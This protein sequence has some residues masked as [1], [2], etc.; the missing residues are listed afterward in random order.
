VEVICGIACLARML[1]ILDW[2]AGMRVQVFSLLLQLLLS[3]LLPYQTQ[4]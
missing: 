4:Q 1:L 3:I 2:A